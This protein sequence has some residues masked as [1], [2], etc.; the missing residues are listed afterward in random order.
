M[1]PY[2]LLQQI[3]FI[4]SLFS[5]E[6]L[7]FHQL[8]SNRKR[9]RSIVFADK[10]FSKGISSP[11]WVGLKT[12]C[13]CNGMVYSLAVTHEGFRLISQIWDSTC[14]ENE[15]VMDPYA[16]PLHMKVVKHLVYV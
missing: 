2:A 13:Y 8:L 15:V 3:L 7:N 9:R 6:A 14:R 5:E 12:H 16:H 11:L 4:L 10:Y 1:D